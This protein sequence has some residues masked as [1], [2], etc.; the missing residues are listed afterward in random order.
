MLRG[1]ESLGCSGHMGLEFQ[2]F[3]LVT[4]LVTQSI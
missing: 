1:E 3:W 4:K 2:F